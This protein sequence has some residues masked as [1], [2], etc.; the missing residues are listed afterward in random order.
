MIKHHI[1][2]QSHLIYLKILKCPSF[3][4]SKVSSHLPSKIFHPNIPI[5]AIIVT[6]HT[7]LNGHPFNQ[8]VNRIHLLET[9]L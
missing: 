1:I 2:L 6:L 3:L 4:F 5:F 9:P 7:Q 8:N